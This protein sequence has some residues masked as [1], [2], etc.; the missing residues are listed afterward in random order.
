MINI[1]EWLYYICIILFLV[2]IFILPILLIVFIIKPSIV[3]NF[4]KTSLS[5]LKIFGIGSG[6]IVFSFFAS[7]IIGGANQPDNIN[8]SLNQQ[9]QAQSEIE[10]LKAQEVKTT[11]EAE[12]TKPKVSEVVDKQPVPFTSEQKEDA[13]LPKG[14]TKVTQVGRNGEQTTIYE[15]TTV[16]GVE[17]ARKVK[18]Q[19]ISIQ[20]V[21]Q[22]TVIGTYT[23]PAPSCPNGTYVNSAGNTV[24]SPSA[25]STAPPGA[26]AKC[27][28]GTYSFSQSR[29]GTCSG[30]GGVAVWL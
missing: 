25:S 14:Q 27:Y 18:S 30:H 11:K 4:L 23:A 26:T 3:N 5:R 15:V 9:Q 13:S 20:P 2:T 16:K 21:T 17:T 10:K 8:R 24:C 28:D 6:F 29:R 7:A 12:L 22:I 19:A 1:V